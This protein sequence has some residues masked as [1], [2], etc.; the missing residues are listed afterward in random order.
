MQITKRLLIGLVLYCQSASAQTSADTALASGNALLFADQLV[1][2][3]F[4]QDWQAYASLTCPSAIKYYGGKDGFRDHIVSI[5]YRD[6]PTVAEKP[7]TL[8]MV[9]LLNDMDRWQCVVQ[10]IRDTYINN[11]KAKIYT[12]LVGQ[13]LDNGA[14]WKFIDV[15]HNDIR[16]VIY[17]MPDIFNTMPIPD[18][19]TAFD[20]EVL[21]QENKSSKKKTKRKKQR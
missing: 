2:A 8:K 7:E 17:I 12:Y 14:T 4:Y 10:K 20:D 18:R 9:T 11:R 15:N 5:Y 13:S 19:K 1:K 6:E 16:N 3:N 21:A